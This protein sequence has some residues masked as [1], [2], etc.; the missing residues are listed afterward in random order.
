L[1]RAAGESLVLSQLDPGN[2]DRFGVLLPHGGALELTDE[3][4]A[5]VRTSL[6]DKSLVWLSPA[7]AN[8]L[9]ARG[10][11]NPMT[12]ALDAGGTGIVQ[13][14]WARDGELAA[15]GDP[16]SATEPG[17]PAIAPAPR[18]SF[19]G[20]YARSIGRAFVV[21]GER[22]SLLKTNTGD[23]WQ[24][25]LDHVNWAR[26]PTG[27]YAPQKVLAAT[28]SHADGRLWVLD[29]FT[30]KLANRNLSVTSLRLTRVD[31][32]SGAAEVLST[33]QV[34]GLTDRAWL[35][36]DREGSI[37][38][39]TSSSLQ[40]SY[41]VARVVFEGPAARVERQ[42][43]Y[44]GRLAAPPVADLTG[45]RL[46]RPAADLGKPQL[47]AIPTKLSV[48][49]LPRVSDGWQTLAATVK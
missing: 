26:L 29:Q 46:V 2:P 4:D 40:N 12:L 43:T 1:V 41:A 27:D 49:S 31:I 20:V 23:I 15:G 44:S 32:V 11:A 14:I 35:V 36:T 10:S 34:Q 17:T 37:L 8:S 9:R 21:G 13:S 22:G 25:S 18:K 47:G 38:L 19:V 48:A 24:R 28:W 30:T 5:A 45:L 39:V 3:L 33:W 42:K 7:E 16:A 6:A